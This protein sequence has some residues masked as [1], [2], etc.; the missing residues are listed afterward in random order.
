MLLSLAMPLIGTVY[1][2]EL[3]RRYVKEVDTEYFSVLTFVLVYGAI[4]SFL[5]GA[6]CTFG[7]SRTHF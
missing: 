4:N 6:G 2:I 5:W 1:L 3:G 7:L